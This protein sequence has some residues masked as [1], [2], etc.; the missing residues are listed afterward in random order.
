MG[1]VPRTCSAWSDRGAPVLPE[2]AHRRHYTFRIA[3]SHGRSSSPPWTLLP[4]A[5]ASTVLAGSVGVGGEAPGPCGAAGGAPGQ[6]GSCTSQWLQGPHHHVG[7]LQQGGG[8]GSRGQGKGHLSG[9]RYP[10]DIGTRACA[11]ARLSRRSACRGVGC[12]RG[13]RYVVLASEAK[14]WVFCGHL[15]AA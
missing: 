7:P 2:T 1:R 12:P 3:A 13:E 14:K 15:R 10:R 9:T 6:A 8:Q 11:R 4:G 5:Q